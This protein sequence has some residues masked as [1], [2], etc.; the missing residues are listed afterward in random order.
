[1]KGWYFYGGV[2]SNEGENA[3]VRNG[4]VNGIIIRPDGSVC[5]PHGCLPAGGNI[6]Y[7]FLQ[8]TW[9]V[10]STGNLLLYDVG[11]GTFILDIEGAVVDVP[12]TPI[13]DWG[14]NLTYILNHFQKTNLKYAHGNWHLLNAD[15]T[16]SAFSLEG[17]GSCFNP[18]KNEHEQ[19]I[20]APARIYDT[21]GSQGNWNSGIVSKSTMIISRIWLLPQ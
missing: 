7:A 21:A 4:D 6:Y 1:M 20:L 10:T 16:R 2:L 19:I 12:S 15:G 14:I 8:I 17:Y 13:L 9:K 11:N 5:A 3:V 18:F